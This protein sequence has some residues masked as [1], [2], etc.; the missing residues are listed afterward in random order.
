MSEQSSPTDPRKETWR[1]RLFKVL[2]NPK[3]DCSFF[4]VT[5]SQ[6]EGSPDSLVEEDCDQ[7][8]KSM[9]DEAGYP[10]GTRVEMV[11]E[12]QIAAPPFMRSRGNK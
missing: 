8:V 1:K 4:V 6:V 11:E 3:P 2:D 9:L 12:K 5:L 7:L 10:D